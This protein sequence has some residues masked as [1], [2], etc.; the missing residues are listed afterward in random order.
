MPKHP[1]NG[2]GKG[3]ATRDIACSQEHF[4]SEWDRIFGKKKK[5]EVEVD[6]KNEKNTGDG[7]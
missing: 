1:T 5:Q 6:A 2:H 4:A 7:D 3:S